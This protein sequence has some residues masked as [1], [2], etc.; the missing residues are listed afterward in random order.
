MK[1][2][3]FAFVALATAALPKYFDCQHEKC[4]LA[5]IEN[6]DLWLR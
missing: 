6:E 3:A 5:S 1:I 4:F 2:I